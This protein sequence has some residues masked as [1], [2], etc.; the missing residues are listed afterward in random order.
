ME[1]EEVA[2]LTEWVKDI[3]KKVDNLNAK[4]NRITYIIIGII[5]VPIA[6]NPTTINYLLAAIRLIP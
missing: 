5:V 2:V 4:F 6:L 3:S 1:N